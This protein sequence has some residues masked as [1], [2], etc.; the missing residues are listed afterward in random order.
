MMNGDVSYSAAR[1]CQRSAQVISSFI[2]SA[3]F[4]INQLQHCSLAP[5]KTRSSAPADKPSSRSSLDK[6]IDRRMDRNAITTA[7]STC[8]VA[9]SILH[10]QRTY[11]TKQTN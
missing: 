5:S 10:T 7:F 4:T 8:H 6:Q 1:Q 2:I 11:N 3:V 9:V